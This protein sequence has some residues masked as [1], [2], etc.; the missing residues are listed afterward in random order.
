M[1]SFIVG[2]DTDIG[3]T[4]YGNQL[5]SQ[6]YKVIK[7]IE[8]G[9]KSFDN[10][11]LSDSYQYASKQSLPLDQVNLYFFS[12]PVSPHLAADMDQ[13]LV[14]VNQLTQFIKN[15]GNCFVELA[16]GLMVPITREL[17]QFDFI[18][19][20]ENATVDLVIGN[21]LGCINHALLTIKVLRD[22]DIPIRHVFINN[23]GPETTMSLDN[24]KIIQNY[25]KTSAT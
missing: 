4:Y 1:L 25:I 14:D 11:E 7:P 19:S 16:G 18:K 15:A 9:K 8:T 12:E 5:I 21:K 10:L 23:M 24:E 22:S 17:T 6:G 13:K 3:K 2:T 20:F